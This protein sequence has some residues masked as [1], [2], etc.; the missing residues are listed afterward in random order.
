MSAG[1]CLY[2]SVLLMMVAMAQAQPGSTEWIGGLGR[3]VK[4]EVFRSPDAAAAPIL[5]V[6]LHGDA[7]FERPSYQY[8]FAANAA[9]QLHG[10]V[11]AALLRPGYTDQEGDR[12]DGD[13]GNTTA[14]NYTPEVLDRLG[15]AIRRLKEELHSPKVVLVGHSGG[16]AI[17]AD[18]IARDRG[19]ANAALLV[20]CPCDVPAFREHMK[21]VAPTPLWDAPVR[22]ISPLDVVG[23]ISKAVRIEM[24]VGEKD[25]VAPP[26]LTERYAAALKKR[27][28]EGHV[29]LLP[30][31]G[32]EIL[33]D[34]AIIQE[35][36]VLITSL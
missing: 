19:L 4:A 13:R 22:S 33:L 15:A 3:R 1:T 26:D 17:A 16:A 28:I 2:L 14:D 32:H 34:P 27:G 20:S 7:P 31:K 36:P 35:L 18:L 11:V 10:V 25:K 12:S 23:D 24:V 30:A 8:R 5:V 29:I 6:V 9:K 21:T